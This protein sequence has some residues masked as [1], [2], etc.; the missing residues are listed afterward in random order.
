MFIKSYLKLYKTLVLHL[1]E[2]KM[3]GI[4]AL[5]KRLTCLNMFC[6]TNNKAKGN[7]PQLL[8]TQ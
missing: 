3:L 5:G 4:P 7:F 1:A 2:Q 6:I 8:Q